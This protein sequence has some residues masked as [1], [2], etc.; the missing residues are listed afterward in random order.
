MDDRD[1]ACNILEGTLKDAINNLEQ[2]K[3]CMAGWDWSS[4]SPED[5]DEVIETL[6]KIIGKVEM[7]TS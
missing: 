2:A 6:K 5:I 3:E 7:E 1:M 4:I